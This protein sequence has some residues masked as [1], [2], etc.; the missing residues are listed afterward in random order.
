M[1]APPRSINYMQCGGVAV[2]IGGERPAAVSAVAAA[3]G[4]SLA[5]GRQMVVF[6]AQTQGA[7]WIGVL[8]ASVLFGALCGLVAR[9]AAQTGSRSFV[10]VCA[11]TLSGRWGMAVGMLYGLILVLA[12]AAMLAESG[13]LAELALPLHK[14]YWMGVVLSLG[15]A[16]ALCIRGMR[17]WGAASLALWGAFYVA[18]ALDPRPVRIHGDYETE[19]RLAG[20][21]PAAVLLGALHAGMSGSVAAGSVASAGAKSPVRLALSSGGMMLVLLTVANAALLR[22][23]ER[24]FSQAL[25]MVV[26]AARWGKVGFYG[27]ILVKWMCAVATISAAL[28]ALTGKNPISRER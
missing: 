21:V 3:A 19:L 1:K 10:D 5:S 14:A 27:C 22:G 7:S 18:L 24:L 17:G 9:A 28:G 13:R 16:S 4:V 15:L 8:T 12:A 11:R 26:L 25:P 2:K 6:F 23:G 20:S